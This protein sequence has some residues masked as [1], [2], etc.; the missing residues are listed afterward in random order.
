MPTT[1]PAIQLPLQN[2]EGTLE[3]I[4]FQNDENGYT[5]AKLIPAG[6]RQEVTIVG[7]LSGINVGELLRLQGFWTNHP[8]YGRQFE[9]S[10]FSVHY[11][12]TVEGI[13]KYLGSGLVRGVGPVTASKIVDLFGADT[14]E[15]IETQSHRLKEVSG[16][17][18][19]RIGIIVSAWEEQKQVKE[20]MLFLQSHGVSTSLAVKIYKQYADQSIPIVK[21]DPYRLAK[22]IYG[23]GFKTADKIARQLGMPPDSPSR[24]QAGLL[25]ALGSLS[26]D[27]HCFA[28]R[29]QLLKEAQQLLEV[30][31]C[32]P[33]LD[34]LIADE[35]LIAE[36]VAIYLPPFFRAEVGTA[37]RI[38]RI[39]QADRD[40]L[41]A[42]RS[43]DWDAAFAMLDRQNP[44]RLTD[45]QKSA[46]R[47]ALTN[48]VSV[49]TGGPGT[50]KSTITASIISMLRTK[51]GR[52]LLAAPTGRAAKRLT[53]TT[54]VEAKTIHRLLE[55]RPSGKGLFAR[56]QANPL[57]ADLLIIDEAS[58]I[59][60]LLI[61]HLLDA[62]EIGMHILFVGDVDQLP[63]VGPGNVLRDLIASEV[64]PVTRL[65]TI[66]RQSEDSFIIVNAHNIN[67][68]KYP[69]FSQE[70]KDFF[71]FAE[72][73]PE[74]AANWVI[75][76]VARRIKAKFGFD[77][78]EDIQVLSP[79]H[80]GSAGV[81]ELNQ[82]LQT[83]INPPAP[84]KTEFRHGQRVFRQHD[85]VMQTVNNYDLLVFNGDLGRIRTINLEDQEVEVEFD[86]R[87]VKYELSQMDELVHAYAISIHKSQGS[88]FP[89]VVIPVLNQHYMMLQRN[90]LYTAVT[91]ARKLVVLVGSKQAIGMAL[92]N[93]RISQRNTRLAQ[94][95]KTAQ[96]QPSFNLYS[97]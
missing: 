19:K 64:I 47:M 31:S 37:N 32:E 78:S 23:I 27:G 96:P 43:L 62:V 55:Y 26:N 90:L 58:M 63:S 29:E 6:G 15:I 61:N 57:D 70:S 45:Q 18:D 73:D 56:D 25:H 59:D 72:P 95:I 50:G 97:A 22:D 7:T 21:S 10:A 44:I 46:V 36:D 17:G 42:F 76:L 71:L 9:V 11:P 38:R 83:E 20:I 85:R 80:R 53:E 67:Q 13:R 49:L 35:E 28:T 86:G 24:I 33:Q 87:P 12:A 94:R 8:Q 93:N 52:V 91:R 82:R 69:I 34:H 39:Q 81:G 79:M 48:K 68:G 41:G 75:D 65:D 51:A 74:K 89:V 88:E 16:I 40:R 5:I 14:L 2:L 4:T 3:R 84:S 66:F 77:P 30:L 1:S 92:R 60:I 54:S